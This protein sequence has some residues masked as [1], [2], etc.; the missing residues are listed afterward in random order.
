MENLQEEYA[1]TIEKRKELLEQ[2]STLEK[3]EKVKEFFRLRKE[4]NELYVL[5][6]K[7]Y[8][9]IKFKEY[10][11][12][13][14]IWVIDLHDYDSWEGRSYNTHGCIK[15]GLDY[16]VINFKDSCHSKLYLQLE[17]QAMYDYL[18]SDEAVWTG[19]KTRIMCD[20]DLGRAIYAKIKE[21]HPNIDDETALKYFEIALHNIRNNRVSE[22]RKISRARRLS[23]DPKFNK[24]RGYD[25]EI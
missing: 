23:L 25:I 2:I 21:A 17:Q 18:T 11:S 24:W 16:R 10:A 4:N 20:L 12:C 14:H 1:K 15:C 22:E 3:D 9:E 19:K 5:E 13:N 7:L 6:T 8:K